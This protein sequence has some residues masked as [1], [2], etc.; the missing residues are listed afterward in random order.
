[1]LTRFTKPNRHRGTGR[2]GAAVVEMA[3]VAPVIIALLM[4]IIDYGWVMRTRQT[5]SIAAREGARALAASSGTP[6]AAVDRAWAVL[7]PLNMNFEPPVAEEEV[8]S[9]RR[10][11]M[12]INIWM[13]DAS[14]V[15]NPLGLL[16]GD[17]T[18][19]VTMRKE[20]E[21]AL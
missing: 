15:G 18:V 20:V 13:P 17:M 8:G 5:M 10:V 9:D 3:V 14:M 11:S 21:L 1:M 4:G 12:T 6:E 2:K 19:K 7:E 16:R